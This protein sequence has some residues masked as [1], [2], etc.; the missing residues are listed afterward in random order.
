MGASKPKL[1][2]AQDVT[3]RMLRGYVRGVEEGSSAK[4]EHATLDGLIGALRTVHSS[5]KVGWLL[6][7]L[8]RTRTELL[9]G[10][11]DLLQKPREPGGPE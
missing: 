5:D 6:D 2:V 4:L 3:D 10:Q 11:G 7:A 8:R 1:E 9:E